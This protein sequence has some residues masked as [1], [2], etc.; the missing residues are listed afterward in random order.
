MRERERE[1][2]TYSSRALPISSLSEP[3][4]L[5]TYKKKARREENTNAHFAKTDKLVFLARKLRTYKPGKLGT[6]WTG[7][8]NVSLVQLS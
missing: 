4:Q 7:W 6:C 8:G 5:H 2:D 1:G 3:N